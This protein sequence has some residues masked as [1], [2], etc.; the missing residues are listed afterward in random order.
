VEY[1]AG[2]S[3]QTRLIAVGNELLAGD[4]TDTN[5]PYLAKRA[6]G[7]GFPV[8]HIEVVPDDVGAIAAAVRRAV[9]D[10]SASR[11]V[12]SGGVGPTHDDVTLEGV[13]AGLDRPLELNPTVYERIAATTAR[14]HEAG[15]LPTAEVSPAHRRMAV[16]AAGATVLDNP[17]GMASPFAHAVGDDRW[18]FVLPGVPREFRT[19]VDDVLIPG[20]FTG[21]VRLHSAEI[22]FHG[23]AESRLASILE[24]VESEF[25]DVSVG[26][27]PHVE[28]RELTIRVRGT[29]P[30]RLQSALDRIAELAPQDD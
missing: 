3:N 28:T 8:T 22:K 4:I 23:I 26:S 18:L 15:R 25:D 21:G 20:F 29:D 1:P 19:V 14:L 17:R 11:I 12:V 30:R 9:A 16:A 7:A 2:V 10:E 24:Q 13:A 6:F 5:S 27:Y